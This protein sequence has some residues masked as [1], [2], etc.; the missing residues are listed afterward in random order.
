MPAL[1]A[2]GWRVA[3]FQSEAKGTAVTDRR[4]NAPLPKAGK[5]LAVAGKDSAKMD[6]AGRVETLQ[7]GLVL[8]AG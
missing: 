8:A 6:Q 1:R 5:T 4:Y 2:F 3:G 7:L